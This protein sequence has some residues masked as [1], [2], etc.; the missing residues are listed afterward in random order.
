MSSVVLIGQAPGRLGDPARPLVGKGSGDLLQRLTG[1]MPGQY[2]RLF[3]R[4]NLLG[5][6]PGRSSAG[7]DSFPQS[8]AKHAAQAI[9][10]SL[11]GRRVVLLG[12]GVARA[13]GFSAKTTRF[14]WVE[15]DGATFAL[16][17]HPSQVNRWWNN[18]RNR[19]EAARFFGSILTS[20]QR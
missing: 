2:E 19:A 1:A 13:F 14:R 7:G 8:E 3:E 5:S 15:R 6:W 4:R 11:A 18:P 9:L 10:P 12:S 16:S 20:D 17:P